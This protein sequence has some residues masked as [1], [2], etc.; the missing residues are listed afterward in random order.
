MSMQAI[1][2][3]AALEVEWQSFEGANSEHTGNGHASISKAKAATNKQPASKTQPT[4]W[5][6]S[7]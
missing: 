3:L 5:G 1:P 7:D 6:M 4:F 2:R